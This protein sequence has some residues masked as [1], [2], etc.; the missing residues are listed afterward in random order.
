MMVWGADHMCDR[1]VL[2][3]ELEHEVPGFVHSH[4]KR[5]E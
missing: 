1:T 2:R 5:G 4:H 3:L